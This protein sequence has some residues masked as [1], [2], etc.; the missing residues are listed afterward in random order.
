[1]SGSEESKIKRH[2][3]TCSHIWHCMIYYALGLFS[4]INYLKDKKHRF[5]KIEN[6]VD[7]DDNNFIH[8][9]MHFK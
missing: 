6:T 9:F 1:M 4:L 7:D 8:Q 5:T 3:I 2:F